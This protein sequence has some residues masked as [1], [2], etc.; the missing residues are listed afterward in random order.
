MAVMV[1]FAILFLGEY[2]AVFKQCREKMVLILQCVMLLHRLFKFACN[3][4]LLACAFPIKPH[5]N[6]LDGAALSGL[7]PASIGLKRLQ[8]C[9]IR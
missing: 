5:V 9:G 2:N 7:G 6:Y 8:C 4:K 1:L 3:G